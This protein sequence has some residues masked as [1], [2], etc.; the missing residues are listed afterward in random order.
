MSHTA[1]QLTF[2]LREFKGSRFRCLLSTSLPKPTFVKWINSL[3]Q[4]FAEVSESDKYMP[5][6]FSRPDEAK[7]GETPGFLDA[8][9]GYDKEKRKI[10][11][12]WW[13]AV[14]RNA[15]TPNWDLASTCKVG[16]REGLVL[17]EAKAHAGELKSDDCCGAANQQ[18]RKRIFQAIAEASNALG[19]GWSLTADRCYQLNNRIAWS[20]K[21]ASLGRPVV[22]V[23]LGF[24]NVYEMDD[25]FQNQAAWEHCLDE[26]ADG[27]VP[28]RAWN[29]RVM[30]NGTPL[31]PLIR[32]ADVSVVAI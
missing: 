18:N 12:D 26:Y 32:S 7:L 1:Q 22:L 29:S 11:T 17:L 14:R 10:L 20:L 21:I 25:P 3:V 28:E 4:P 13:L 31:V 16:G 27:C 23:Y 8:E 9:Q 6:G 19:N 15:N 24:L 5:E 30:V 2:E